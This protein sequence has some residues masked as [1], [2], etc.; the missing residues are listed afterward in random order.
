MD[1][2]VTAERVD[3][4]FSLCPQVPDKGIIS[5]EDRFR[6]FIL[7]GDDFCLGVGVMGEGG[8]PIQVV[9]RY[10]EEDGYGSFKLFDVL[11]L[12]AWDFCHVD[13]SVSAIID[14]ADE[15]RSNIPCQ[16]GWHPAFQEDFMSKGGCG[17]FSVRA[18]DPY[19]FAL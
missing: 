11:Q 6:P 2:V 12:E 13:I 5:V 8:M 10:V 3:S 9:R 15:G 17:R 18:S 16:K 14:K 1:S 7:E 19:D 4:W